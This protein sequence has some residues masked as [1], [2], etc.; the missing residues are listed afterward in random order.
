MLASGYTLN[1]RLQ[2]VGEMNYWNIE[3]SSDFIKI[4]AQLFVTTSINQGSYNGLTY[5]SSK[6]TRIK[7]YN[8]A[9][10]SE[11]W[12]VGDKIDSPYSPIM[13]A[14]SVFGNYENASAFLGE[15]EPS[16]VLSTYDYY[17]EDYKALINGWHYRLVDYRNGGDSGFP[18]F[19]N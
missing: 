9:S 19:Y 4:N 14:S 15:D 1:L 16:I 12:V 7:F 17:D 10:Q 2:I 11:N 13:I 18:T 5:D 3:N 6:F 8:N